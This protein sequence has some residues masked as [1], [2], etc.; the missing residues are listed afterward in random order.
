MRLTKEK[1]FYLNTT[2]QFIQL[3]LQF[4]KSIVKAVYDGH[5]TQGDP[6][7]PDLV[8]DYGNALLAL[9]PPVSIVPLLQAYQSN[10]L[11]IFFP[12]R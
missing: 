2:I 11:N 6:V 4:E 9:H 8:R 7:I 1:S 5:T 12:P 10:V 3:N